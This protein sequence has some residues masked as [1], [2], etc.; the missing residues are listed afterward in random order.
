M[1]AGE[2]GVRG[3]GL[4]C[5][6][7]PCLRV[8]LVLYSVVWIRK[9]EET[10]ERLACPAEPIIGALKLEAA[11]SPGILRMVQI[12]NGVRSTL[13]GKASWPAEGLCRRR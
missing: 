2:I 5:V 6:V 3:R 1:Y 13:K 8:S 11:A 10:E 4:T 7:Q 9:V 12:T